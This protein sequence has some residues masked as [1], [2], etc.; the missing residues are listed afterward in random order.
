MKHICIFAAVF[1]FIGGVFFV[2]AQDRIILRDGS[3]IEADVL[4]ISAAE[5]RYRR[6]DHLDGPVI[7]ISVPLVMSIMYEN[8]RVE[9]IDPAAAGRTTA[10]DTDR[11]VFGLSADL[12]GLFFDDGTM[13]NGEF[14]KGKFFSQVNFRF[15]FL[16]IKET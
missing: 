8:G 11:L 9:V 7:V 13:F 3:V 6:F 12:S 10:M 2:N 15:P 4:E 5:I 14:T 1:L 16:S